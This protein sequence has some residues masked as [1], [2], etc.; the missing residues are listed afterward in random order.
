M[1][2]QLMIIEV[3]QKQA[4]IFSS[5]SLKTN[6]RRSR[7]ISLVT[8]EAYF[9]SVCPEGYDS[10]VN[11]VY[12]GGGHAVLQFPDKP[13][14]DVFAK[15]LT[16]QVLRD[17]PEM[18]LFIR[19]APYRTDLTPSENLL[20]LSKALEKKK[21]LR[22]ASFCMKA[23][24]IEAS[25]DYSRDNAL[26]QLAQTRQLAIIH[27]DG[28]A[29]GTRVAKVYEKSGA[30]W[31]LCIANLRQFSAGIEEDFS[32]A[33]HAMENDLFRNAARIS[34]DV[35][36][37]HQIIAAGDDLCFIVSADH[38]LECAAS[39]L[40]HLSK[41]KNVVDGC[42]YSACAGIAIVSASSEFRLGYDVS[43]TL[44]ANAKRFAAA[45][46]PD[47]SALDFQII[48]GI[49]KVSL[50]QM[51]ASYHADDGSLLYLRPFAVTGNV[52]EIYTYRHLTD[53]LRS[54]QTAK[55]STYRAL[56]QC[57]P[58]F[59][60][61]QQEA[62]YALHMARAI[63]AVARMLHQ[64]SENLDLYFTDTDGTRRCLFFDAFEI[65][66]LTVLWEGDAHE[67]NMPQS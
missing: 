4:Y 18:E 48:T 15:A 44:C 52:P 2:K 57:R 63:P 64:D 51:R 58:A 60:Q 5:R 19:Q 66:S 14:A 20:E 36:T 47:V 27:I 1:S 42:Y 26:S 3:S 29:M 41:R 17:Y 40:Q 61:G 31:D 50:Q 8:S 37:L 30:D 25:A 32:F 22:S 43:E 33:Y 62:R 35:P 56:M 10:A 21:S 24:G 49:P 28:N 34:A 23:L 13:A 6:Q 46:G 7:E 16:L 65:S 38:A 59:H 67:Q 55:E 45:Y 12:S 54:I 39:F 53:T 9:R 11:M